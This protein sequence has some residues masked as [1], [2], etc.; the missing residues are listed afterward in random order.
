LRI[1]GMQLRQAGSLEPG[2]DDVHGLYAFEKDHPD[3]DGA[4]VHGT[5]GRGTE[6][7]SV[8][9]FTPRADSAAELLRDCLGNRLDAAGAIGATFTTD[10]AG[11]LTCA[12]QKQKDGL[13]RNAADFQVSYRVR[14]GGGLQIM[15]AA[16]VEA[17]GRWTAI[18]AIEICLDLQGDENIA[19]AAGPYKDCHGSDRPRNGRTHLVF[20]NVFDLRTQGL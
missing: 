14:I 17:S 9:V 16:E 19:G 5:D 8:S 4:P 6:P 1:I 12:S 20:R 13:I 2:R 7:D 3:T 15:N 18:E 11:Q 10:R